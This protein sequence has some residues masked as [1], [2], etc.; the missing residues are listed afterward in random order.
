MTSI[1]NGKSGGKSEDPGF[2]IKSG[3]T[4][5]IAKTEAKQRIFNLH[6][7]TNA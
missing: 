6:Q 4:K 2:R 1:G 3:M 5:R 7:V